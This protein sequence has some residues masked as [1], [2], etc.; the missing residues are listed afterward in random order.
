MPSRTWNPAQHD[1]DASYKLELELELENDQLGCLQKA[2]EF[3]QISHADGMQMG[4][5]LGSSSCM[6]R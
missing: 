2:Q 3:E 4:G 6:M 1:F 5:F